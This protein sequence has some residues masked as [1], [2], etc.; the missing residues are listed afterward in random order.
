M[1][2]I[3]QL[4]LILKN[5]LKL[6]YLDR[7]L[8]VVITLS[9]EIL[10]ISFIRKVFN[11]H[12]L[13]LILRA[14]R[15]FRIFNFVLPTDSGSI[16]LHLKS[17]DKYWIEAF[18]IDR[19][20][21]KEVKN[22]LSR[23]P[24]QFNFLDL[25]SNIGYWAVVANTI[26]NCS[27]ITCVEANPR[28][29]TIIQKNLELNSVT[30]EIIHTAVVSNNDSF[31]FLNIPTDESQHASSSTNFIADSMPE[32][33]PATNLDLLLEPLNQ[34]SKLIVVKMD[35]E[36]VEHEIV[37]NSNLINNANCILIYEEHGSDMLHKTSRNLIQNGAHILYFL[38][39]ELKPLRIDSVESLNKLKNNPHKGYNCLAVSKN[40]TL[41]NSISEL[42]V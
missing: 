20:Y 39:A 22:F 4:V 18:L 15:M 27:K 23:I 34:N 28:L 26:S 19:E 38:S 6:N 37:L 2:Y 10:R 12:G 14:I 3:H 5:N 32:K 41:S 16:A 24:G 7:I 8:L 31:T 29:I 35:L 36:G 30:A 9:C 40:M 11:N 17:N 25:G 21:E 1:F 13:G 33:V 42:Y